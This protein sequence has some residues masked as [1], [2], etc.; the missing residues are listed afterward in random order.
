[1]NQNYEKIMQGDFDKELL[2]EINEALNEELAK[3]PSERDYD[4][5][6]ELTQAYSELNGDEDFVEEAAERGVR[7]LSEKIRGK[8]GVLVSR[9]IRRVITVGVAAAVLASANALTL[10]A[11]NQNIVS[12][13]IE[14]TENA[15]SATP[16]PK[17]VIDLPTTPDDPYGIKGECKKYG[18]DVE[19]PTYLPEG[20]VLWKIEKEDNDVR[21]GIIFSYHKDNAF[22]TIMFTRLQDDNSRGNIPSDFFNLEEITVNGKP[23]ITSKEDGQYTLLYYDGNMEYCLFSNNLN[24]AECDKIAASI[25]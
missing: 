3:K 2:R 1:M 7:I 11:N 14:K 16:I 12:F 19:A 25:K 18:F 5:I 17:T 23:A 4:K 8:H 10:Y 15:F 21:K 22:M 9:R 20:Y 24:Y 6:A 13:I